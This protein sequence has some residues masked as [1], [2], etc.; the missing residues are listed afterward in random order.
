MLVVL[1]TVMATQYAT[2]RVTFSYS[3]VHPSNAD[4]RFVGSDNCS[5]DGVRVLRINSTNVNSTSARLNLEFGEWS[6]GMNK[7][8]TAAF[9]IVN[10]EPF[11]INITHVSVTNS[12]S[13]PNYLYIW[14]HGNGSLL[15]TNDSTAVKVYQNGSHNGY[16]AGTT[17]WRLGYG[18]MDPSTMSHDSSETTGDGVMDTPWDDTANVRYNE[19]L[20]GKLNKAWPIGTASRT[21]E[22]ASD[23]VWVQISLVVPDGGA[24]PDVHSG[25][26]EFHFKADTHYGDDS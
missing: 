13:D 23:F 16:H 6:S 24:I 25:T 7:T 1:S 18:D 10:E 26:F 4:I 3:I 21:N 9:A 12:T 20:S 2:T 19:Q 14:L 8:Y 11:A 5:D 15:A 22:N 17:A